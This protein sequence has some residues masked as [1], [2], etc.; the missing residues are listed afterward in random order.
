[1][2]EPYDKRYAQYVSFFSNQ[3]KKELY[4]DAFAAQVLSHNSVEILQ[5]AFA[6][7]KNQD[8]IAAAVA[9]DIATYL[10]GALLPKVDIAS[11]QVTPPTPPPPF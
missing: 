4:T 7:Y 2:D 3:D 11:M 6:R 10:P 1:M 5:A 9:A 8:K